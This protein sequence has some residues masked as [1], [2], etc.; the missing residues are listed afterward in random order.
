MQDKMLNDLE[1]KADKTQNKM[2][3]TNDRMKDAMKKLNDKASNV[4]VYIICLFLLL[5]MVAVVYKVRERGCARGAGTGQVWW[6]L[7]APRVAILER[8][9]APN[10][11]PVPS[12]QMVAKK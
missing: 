12:P 11:Q 10:F 1:S 4:C 5:G 2:D 8:A 7:L 9:H 3:S 6:R